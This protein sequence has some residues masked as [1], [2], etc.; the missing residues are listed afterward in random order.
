MQLLKQIE[1]EIK[2]FDT[3]IIHR[4]VNPDGDAYGSQLGLKWLI[5]QNFK[6]K[7]CYA[8]G[9]SIEWL[10]YVGSFDVI[11]DDNIF[12]NSLVIVTDCANVERI[13]D[14]RFTLAKKVIKIDHHPNITEYGDLMWV[15]TSYTSASEMVGYLAIQLGWEIPQKA[16]RAIFNGIVTDSGR[17]MYRGVSPRTF[18]VA[19]KL[20]STGFDLD[21]LYRNLNT[22][23]LSDLEFTNYIFN[24]FK[25]SSNGLASIVVPISE[26]DKHGLSAEVMN[27]YANTLAGFEEIKM[28]ITFSERTDGQYRVEFR[29]S[30]TIVNELAVKYGGGG[31][32]LASGAIAPDLETVNKII[33]DADQLLK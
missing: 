24:N 27:K 7:R 14:Q 32:A 11:E 31:H 9:E 5:E 33:E 2:D 12:H 28:W 26:M 21:E 18:D 15:D 19:S 6:D 10:N 20:L 13:S 3:I 8:V 17:F 29:S 16:A 23:K 22:K 25:L 30:K 4:H 1:N